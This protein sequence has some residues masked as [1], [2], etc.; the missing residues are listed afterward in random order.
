MSAVSGASDTALWEL[1][2]KVRSPLSALELAA[3]PSELRLSSLIDGL[4]C[5]EAER[6]RRER[7]DLA[8]VGR[9]FKIRSSNKLAGLHFLRSIVLVHDA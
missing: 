7:Q 1:A 9:T 2:A 5:G 4:C 6:G 3:F 8:P